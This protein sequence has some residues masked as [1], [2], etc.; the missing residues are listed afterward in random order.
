[1]KNVEPILLAGQCVFRDERIELR[2]PF[3]GTEIAEISQASKNDAT[4]ACE[5]AE[6]A[7][8]DTRSL[9]AW[10]REEI[11]LRISGSISGRAEA[12]AHG[13][14]LEAAKPL[15]DARREVARAVQTFRI[16]A[17]ESK[18][19]AS[20]ILPLDWMPGNEQ[21][22]GFIRR[23]P[24]GPILGITPFNFPINL[25]AHKIAPAIASGNPVIIKPAPQTP[26][27]ALALG[28]IVVDAGWPGG[29]ISVLPCNNDV[30]A[31]LL[32]DAR[33]RMLSFTGSA[34]VGWQLKAAVPKKRVVLELG[35]NAACIVH[36]DADIEL[37]AQKI[38]AGGFGYAGQ[39][40][41]SVQRVFAHNDVSD[42]LVSSV[43]ERVKKLA[44]GDPMDEATEVGPMINVAAAERIEAWIEEA[45]SAGA[46]LLTGGQ[47]RGNMLSPTVLTD[48]PEGAQL[49][50]EEV[51]G[52]VIFVNRYSEF[53]DALRLVNESRYGLQAA[54][55]TK[56][57]D[58][59]TQAWRTLE[60]GAV[61]IDEATSWRAD[62]MPYGGVKDSGVGREGLR[63]AIEEMTEPR[64][65]ILRM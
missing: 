27:T 28:K 20:E 3:D 32:R 8:A 52:P 5:S 57:W 13:I 56:S 31:T 60:V 64:M 47:R 55:F 25:V 34:M 15:K 40:C 58:L 54:V 24:I 4:A 10:K 19:I 50:C 16:A 38:A 22:A 33:V 29:A 36:S 46:T 63:Y 39:S 51:F 11:L 48:V 30:A 62:H 41:I 45:V 42:Q 43:V 26:M 9:P 35:G 14:A 7:F 12:L 18:H 53:S 44:V 6:K 49:A 37:V 21:R 17:E 65:L 2:N 59:M 1:M 61:L 23:F